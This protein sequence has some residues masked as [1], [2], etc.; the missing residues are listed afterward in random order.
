MEL[1]TA[2]NLGGPGGSIPGMMP[3]G[4]IGNV[5]IG[6]GVDIYG[7]VD[8]CA[9]MPGLCAP[10]RCVNTIGRLVLQFL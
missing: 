7:D 4:E 8:E 5:G 6:N 3:G 9:A 2:A 1:C 10:G